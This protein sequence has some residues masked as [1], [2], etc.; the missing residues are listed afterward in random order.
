MAEYIAP[1]VRNITKLFR[2]ATDEQIAEGRNWYM[3][4]YTIAESLSDR[5][6]VPITQ[7]CGVIAAL[8]PLNGWGHNVNLAARVLRAHSRGER[9]TSGY[10][11]A[12]LEKAHRILDSNPLFT[13]IHAILGGL[14]VQNFFTSIY[15]VGNA[16]VCIDRHA[17]SLAVN[18]RF[19]EGEIPSLTPNRYADV[20]N[21]Y[22]RAADI[23]SKEYGTVFTPAHVQSITWV[24]WREK[25]WSKGAFDKH[26][27][28]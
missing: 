4:A 13:T 24:L 25:H 7:V 14:K 8:S 21:A 9:V 23:L 18:K 11:K 1:S 17:Y 12:N 16:G 2:T 27:S 19:P 3:D 28:I 26:E 20:A 22:T 10:L 5:F 6:N 15:Y